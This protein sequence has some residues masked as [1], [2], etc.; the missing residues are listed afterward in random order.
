MLGVM[1]TERYYLLYHTPVQIVAGYIVG[2]AFG[3]VEF[4]LTEHIPLYYPSSPLGQL[5]RFESWVWEGIGGVGGWS[6][7]GTRGGWGE[8]GFIVNVD[9][10]VEGASRKSKRS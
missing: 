10:P 7:G 2:L 5:R 4:C 8:G 3:A 1:L 9:Q 6:L